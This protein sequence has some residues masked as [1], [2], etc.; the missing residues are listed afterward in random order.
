MKKEQLSSRREIV[1]LLQRVGKPLSLDRIAAE[2]N[3]SG[4]DSQSALAG[5]LTAM[6]RDG[7]LLLGRRGRYGLAQKMDLYA[8]RVVGHR[9]GYGFVIC[10]LDVADLY[11]SPKERYVESLWRQHKNKAQC[12]GQR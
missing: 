7:Q 4:A 1:E 2:L 6:E 3:L 12:L 5:R 11:L 8:G 9:D 10:D